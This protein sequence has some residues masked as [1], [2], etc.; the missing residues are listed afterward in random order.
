[1]NFSL[2]VISFC[3]EFISLKN[4]ASKALNVPLVFAE[5]FTGEGDPIEL[6]AISEGNEV[7]RLCE[8]MTKAAPSTNLFTLLSIIV[9]LPRSFLPPQV[10]Y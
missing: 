2:I 7:I 4:F 3:D 9:F 8:V 6:I 10:S 1:V 5:R